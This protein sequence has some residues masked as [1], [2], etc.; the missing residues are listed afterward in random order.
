MA[1]RRGICFMRMLVVCFLRVAL[2]DCA[3][4]QQPSI[5]LVSGSVAV[6]IER[7]RNETEIKSDPSTRPTACTPDGR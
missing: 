5:V 4:K 6:A 2:T 7:Q 1:A 3:E